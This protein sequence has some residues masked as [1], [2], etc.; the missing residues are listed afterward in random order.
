VIRKQRER[1]RKEE[2]NQ[3]LFFHYTRYDAS[4]S[5]L[6]SSLPALLSHHCRELSVK[7]SSASIV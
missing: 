3:Q 6:S 2:V 7:N 5:R 1:E 4:G